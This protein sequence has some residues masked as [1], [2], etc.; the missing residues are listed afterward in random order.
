MAR[1]APFFLGAAGVLGLDATMGVQFVLYGE[2]DEE[3]IVK[4][5]DSKGR[6]HWERVNGWM[7]GWVPSVSPERVVSVAE[8]E[9]LIRSSREVHR[10]SYGAIE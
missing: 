8:G 9:A 1:A 5:R 2:R 10:H 4:V 6:S 7:R 3:K